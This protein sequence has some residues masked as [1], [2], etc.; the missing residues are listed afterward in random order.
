MTL[1]SKTG[2][3]GQTAGTLYY[4]RVQALTRKGLDNWSHVVSPMVK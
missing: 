1:T 3:S 4:F 2:V